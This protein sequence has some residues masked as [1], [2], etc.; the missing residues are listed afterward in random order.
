[1][2]D[3]PPP[4]QPRRRP[5]SHDV[6]IRIYRPHCRWPSPVWKWPSPISH[7]PPIVH[8]SPA[9]ATDSYIPT[10]RE[11]GTK[12][13]VR[14][15]FRRGLPG[16]VS[17][18]PKFPCFSS[19]R[20]E[21]V[22]GIRQVPREGLFALSWQVVFFCGILSGPLKFT[23]PHIFPPLLSSSCRLA[24]RTGVHV[25]CLLLPP[26]RRPTTNSLLCFCIPLSSLQSSPL[27]LFCFFS[28]G[29]Q[30]TRYGGKEQ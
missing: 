25:T 13:V 28:S 16:I 6:R 24:R 14:P 18:P 12:I 11:G 17:P 20:Y 5:L 30:K 27:L 7:S 22:P 15:C 3:H 21:C 8:P 26:L 29:P 1:M 4:L 9:H 2:Y 23:L 10:P 19:M